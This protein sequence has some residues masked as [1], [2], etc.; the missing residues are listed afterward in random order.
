MSCEKNF[1]VICSSFEFQYDDIVYRNE[2]NEET[3]TNFA[4]L[5]KFA[6]EQYLN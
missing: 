5:Y 1:F 2:A 4:R 3:M 6:N